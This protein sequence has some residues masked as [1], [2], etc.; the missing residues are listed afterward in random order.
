MVLSRRVGALKPSSTLAV[1]AKAAALKAQGVKVLSFAAGEPDFD[2]P[3]RIKAS[4]IEALTR[5][6]TK[7]CP[8]PGDM[9][10]RAVLADKLSKEN[11]IPGVTAEHVVISSGGKHSLYLVFQSLID[12][13][14][15]GEEP[16]EVLLPVPA[17][18]SYA[19]QVELAGGRVVEL[20]TEAR[21]DFKITP[22]QLRRAITPRSRALV[23]NS[24]SNPC[25]TMYTPEELRA[26]GLVAAEAARTVAPELVVISDELYEKVIFGGIP[27]FSIGSMP[28]LAGRTV[29]VNGLSKAFAMTGWR[30][31]YAAGSGE[32]GLALSKAM[33]TLQ[34]QSTTSVASFELP[35]IRT[36]IT[37]CGE[38]VEQMRRAF[39]RRAELIDGLVR[40]I[41]GLI[42]PRPTGA[43]YIFPDVSA[44][45]GKRSPGGVLIESASSFASALL[46]EQ[47][48]ACVPGEDFGSG[49]ERCC[50]FS[51]A[52]SDE[53]ISEGMERLGAF[54]ASL[55]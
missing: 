32:F 20:L 22:D 47:R 25:G 53:Q 23:L 26:I 10:T 16:W 21:G 9:A 3:Q 30:L 11:G 8:V 51:F 42:S 43:V 33:Q 13:P 34:S 50:R 15:A 27:H 28:E 37:Q 12:P 39:A 52:C 48:V 44:H 55:R 40:R 14:G 29:T 36:A 6:E 31:G 54:V 4:A 49:G 5:G 45:F 18:V 24:P 19:P 1:N 41:P 7:Y 38:E 17:W 46:D 2:T 35:A